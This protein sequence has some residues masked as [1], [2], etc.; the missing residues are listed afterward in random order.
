MTDEI[1]KIKN[2][3]TLLDKYTLTEPRF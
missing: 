3:S 1:T 2:M